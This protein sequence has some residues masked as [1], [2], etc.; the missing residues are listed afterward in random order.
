MGEAWAEI[1]A[2][3]KQHK[4]LAMTSI[5][6]QLMALDNPMEVI[7]AAG[8]LNYSSSVLNDSMLT[9]MIE[10]VSSTVG[11]SGSSTKATPA[12]TTAVPLR[13]RPEQI[14]AQT[15]TDLARTVAPI[16]EPKPLD[17]K[18]RNNLPD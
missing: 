10:H 12:A 1:A 11:H 16:E 17:I 6:T 9:A 2:L 3:L 13:S 8:P 15:P 7:A 14:V 5:K 18:F 4:L